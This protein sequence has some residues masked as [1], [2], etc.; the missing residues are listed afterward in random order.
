MLK[1]KLKKIIFNFEK[2][3]HC[4]RHQRQVNFHYSRLLLRGRWGT[5]R[6]PL[7]LLLWNLDTARF[8]SSAS[9]CPCCSRSSDSPQLRSSRPRS[10]WFLQHS[11]LHGAARLCD[12]AHSARRSNRCHPATWICPQHLGSS[13]ASF[14]TLRGRPVTD[15]QNIETQLVYN[16]ISSL[17]KQIKVLRIW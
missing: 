5:W 11:G 1:S 17:R 8:D 4:Q 6:S 13:S 2:K 12:C 7:Y 15:Y 16:E 9:S 10:C 3:S 14:H